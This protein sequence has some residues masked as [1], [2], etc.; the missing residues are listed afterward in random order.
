MGDSFDIYVKLI[1]AGPRLLLT[2]H[3]GRDSSPSWSPDGTQIGFTRRHQGESAI[4][5]IPA[6]GGP[7]RKVQSHGLRSYYGSSVVAWSPDGNSRAFADKASD[8]DIPSLFLLSL[9]TLERRRVTWP[10]AQSF[11]DWYPA[12]SPD[13]KILAFTR[14]TSEGVNDVYV[15]ATTGGEP[16]RL[17]FDNTSVNGLCWTPEGTSILFF[18]E[19]GGGQRL[20]RIPA[21]GGTPEAL[22]LGDEKALQVGVGSPPAIARDGRRLAY[23][24]TESVDT[25]IWRVEVPRWSD[26]GSS[27]ARF[28]SSTRMDSAA[29]YSPDGTRVAFE[30]SRSSNYEIWVCDSEGANA[31]QLTSIGGGTPRR[32]PDG[33]SIA[34]DAHPEGHSDIYIIDAGGGR[35][36][37][38]TTDASN[39]VVPSWSRDGRWIYLCSNRSG[40]RH[41]WKVPAEG[42][43]AVQVTGRGGFAAFE[44]PNGRFVYYTKLFSPGLWRVPVEGGEE[45]LVL[46]QPEAAYWGYWAVVSEGLYYL[47]SEAKPGPTIEFLSFATRRV[48]RVAA[49]E[50]DPGKWSPSLAVSPD[51]RWILYG[52]LDQFASDIVLVENFR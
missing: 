16:T 13:G 50:R 44:S 6:L 34:F 17:T 2:S 15:V 49:L 1:G 23:A 11:G 51:G 41:V 29:Q 40:D 5:L 3:P 27:P 35:P 4:Y 12:F 30:S 45:T 37:R 7:E 22:A 19:R 14:W 31:R 33:R 25:N 10:P 48:T 20:W 47:N 52:Q 43:E 24:Q 46:S 26:R 18:S 28:I 9:E 39:D 8:Q 42:G 38:L 32:S 36:R 21:S